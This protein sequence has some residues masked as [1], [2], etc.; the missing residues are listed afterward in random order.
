MSES[1][2]LVKLLFPDRNSPIRFFG[3]AFC[4]SLE[5]QS[6]LAPLNQCGILKIFFFFV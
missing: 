4:F 6:I 1:I 3:L 2:I 5:A